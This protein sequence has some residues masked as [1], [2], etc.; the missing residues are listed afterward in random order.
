MCI[1]YRDRTFCSSDCTDKQCYRFL[2]DEDEK[3]AT[4]LNYLIAFS[5]FSKTCEYYKGGRYNDGQKTET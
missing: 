1:T 5:D 3:R 2:S 4:R